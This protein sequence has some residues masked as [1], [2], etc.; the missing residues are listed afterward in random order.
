MNL[1]Y[2][3][4]TLFFLNINKKIVWYNINKNFNE[5][6]T[7]SYF[8]IDLIDTRYRDKIIRTWSFMILH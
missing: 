3:I 4:I 7:M 1:I 5:V 2:S 8:Y 6:V